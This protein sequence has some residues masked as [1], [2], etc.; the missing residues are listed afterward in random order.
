MADTKP[1][2]RKGT[3]NA[4][5]FSSQLDPELHKEFKARVEAEDRTVRAVLERAL[6]YYMDNVPLNGTPAKTAKK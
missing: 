3:K 4:V 5:P 2:G 6:R 1:T